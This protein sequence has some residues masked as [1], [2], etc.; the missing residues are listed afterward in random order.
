MLRKHNEWRGPEGGEEEE[1]HVTQ[2]AIWRPGRVQGRDYCQAKA[3]HRVAE[4]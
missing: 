3:Q 2:C 4:L 1:R